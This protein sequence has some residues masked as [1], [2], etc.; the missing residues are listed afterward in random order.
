[1]D[2]TFTSKLVRRPQTFTLNQGVTTFIGENGSGKSSILESIF[3]DYL[4]NEDQKIICFS[5]GQNELFSD[6]FNTYKKKSTRFIR[7]EGQSIK[8]FYFNYDWV[9]I[10]IF[11]ASQ[12]K[13]DGFVRR[14]LVDHNYIAE[15]D[16]GDDE[17]SEFWFRLRVRKYYTQKIRA[18]IAAEET[19]EFDP[20]AQ[21]LRKTDF[22]ET[23]ENL[24]EGL[25]ID[26]DFRNNDNLVKRW[27]KLD[28]N[29]VFDIFTHKDASKI[30][31]FFAL[32]SHGWLSNIEMHE[33]QLKFSS[34]LEFKYL[35]D[36]EYQLL[37]MYALLDLF[38]APNTIFLLDEVDSHLYYKNVKKLWNRLDD[39][40]GRVLTTTHSADSLLNSNFDR[41]RYIKSGRIETGLAINELLKRLSDIIGDTDQQYFIA[42]R[43]M[44]IVL[45]DDQDDW[46][47]FKKLS[48]KKLG[49]GCLE[50]LDKIIP[51]KRH[52]GYNN[53]NMIFGESK[54]RFVKEFIIAVD[55]RE[56]Q[57]RNI[58][59]LCDK[60]DLGVNLVG[61]DHRVTI[62]QEFQRL[63]NQSGNQPNY[64]LL[65][66][67]RREIENYLI[68]NSAFNHFDMSPELQRAF[69]NNIP[70]IGNNCDGNGDVAEYR[71]KP[72]THPFYKANG[73]DETQ[74][75]QL[76]AQI[77]AIEISEDIT[78][79]YSF[80]RD[81]L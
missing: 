48:V 32:S 64:F 76:I 53:P 37:S 19:G 12:L 71:C 69:P 10:L 9:R 67:K 5:S 50:I 20:E 18:E 17:S 13:R 4:D 62:P 36:G 15:N 66:W 21:L 79:L 81:N 72:L 16:L 28:S 34:G 7:E 6:L 25:E 1:M 26:F 56:I 41:I 43:I 55:G 29:N 65:S 24:I 78:H 8:S 31:S 30:F 80:F 39:I 63:R 35:S 44:D 11:F 77:P 42:S 46:T 45:V 47:I 54:L 59:A 49:V 40:E 2:I 51:V 73:F 70:A 60:D 22:H 58:F 75:D 61:V 68:S 14:Y 23:L 38:D 27:V 52:S 3:E 33:S 57:T 74:L